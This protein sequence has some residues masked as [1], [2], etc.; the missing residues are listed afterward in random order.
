MVKKYKLLFVMSVA[1]TMI[2]GW[3]LIFFGGLL[4]TTASTAWQVGL[5]LSALL[6]SSMGFI[7]AKQWGWLK[8]N[9]GRAVIFLALGLL[10]WGI[11]ISVLAFYLVINPDKE[12]P[13]SYALDIITI[14]AIPVWIYGILSLSRATGARY[15]LKTIRSRIFAIILMI[16]L[17]LLAYVLLVTIARGGV[18]ISPDKSLWQS[19]FD[20]SI[21]IGDTILLTLSVL[22]F[23]YSWQYLGGR[24][25]KY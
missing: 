22:I 18:L 19:F 4:D 12:V 1:A 11:G 9:I 8:S 21:P 6:F 20:I 25:K 5:A 17:S 3:F 24:F 15:G 7:T 10:L 23:I 13:Q 16:C 2:G 14:S